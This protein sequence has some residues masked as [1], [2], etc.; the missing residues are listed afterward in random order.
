MHACNPSAQETEAGRSGVPGQ[1]GTV[2]EHYAISV[3]LSAE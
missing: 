2:D 3:C 1:R